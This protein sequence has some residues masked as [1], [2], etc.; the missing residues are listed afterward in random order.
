MIKRQTTF[1]L[2]IIIILGIALRIYFINQIPLLQS[3]DEKYH[4][5]VA[6]NLKDNPSIPM[7]YKDP[8]LNYDKTNWIANH[9]WI[10]KPPMALWFISASIQ[11]FGNTNFAVRFPSLIWSCLS[12]FIIFLIGKKLW[13]DRI[14]LIACFLQATSGLLLDQCAGSWSSDHVDVFLFFIIELYLLS[15]IYFMESKKLHYALTMIILMSI[16][17]MTKYYFCIFILPLTYAALFFSKKL[18]TKEQ[19]YFILAVVISFIPIGFWIAHLHYSVPADTDYFWTTILSPIWQP[20]HN[21]NKSMTYYWTETIK[22][23]GISI[24]AI[25]VYFFYQLYNNN[26]EDRKIKFL[27]NWIIIGLVLLSALATKRFT[28]LIIIAVP[29]FL[30]TAYVID[31][32]LSYNFEKKSQ[33]IKY[34][35]VLLIIALPIRYCIERM[36]INKDHSTQQSI[37]EIILNNKNTHDKTIFMHDKHYIERMFYTNDIAYVITADS[38]QL[39]A[40]NHQNYHIKYIKNQ[41]DSS[42]IQNASLMEIVVVPDAYFLEK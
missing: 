20:I 10:A 19:F 17:W 40:L 26:L 27:F 35:I 31:R 4:A 18:E 42:T 38:L 12:L 41:N 5:L 32:I 22:V 13:N 9:I 14:G 29:M 25:I 36:K 24:V 21:H 11:V 2:L 34:F 28:Y 8:I 33:W 7:L 37:K 15:L 39:I 6:K 23:F 30:M 3:W 1:Y 16:A